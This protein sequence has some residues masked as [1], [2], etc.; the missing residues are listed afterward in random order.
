MEVKRLRWCK[1]TSIL[2]VWLHDEHLQ[3]TIM[4]EERGKAGA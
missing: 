1:S 2:D 4:A 3:G